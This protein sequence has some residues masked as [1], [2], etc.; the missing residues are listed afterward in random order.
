VDVKH[1]KLLDVDAQ[2]EGVGPSEPGVTV[3]HAREL[4]E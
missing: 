4:N 1:K 2:G 3:K